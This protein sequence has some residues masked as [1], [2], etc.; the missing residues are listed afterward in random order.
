MTTTFRIKRRA[1]VVH[2][3]VLLTCFIT[4]CASN[5]FAP[6]AYGA[7]KNAEP[8]AGVLAGYY[9]V[10]A[11]DT[12]STVAQAFGRDTASLARWNGITDRDSLTPGR[13]LR[14]APPADEV[15]AAKAVQPVAVKPA[16]VAPSPSTSSAATPT[17]TP[18]ASSCRANGMSWPVK[19]AVLTPFGKTSPTGMVI[20]G[21]KGDTVY[22]ADAGRVVYAGNGVKGYSQLVIVKHD[23]KLLSA[24]GYNQ[25]A[26]VKDGE[27]VKRGQAI[28]EMGH[29]PSGKAAVL[30][31]VR[32]DRKAVD[33][34]PYLKRCD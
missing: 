21:K 25:R 12:L 28:A 8:P 11:G 19:G 16:N 32:K 31:E 26:L 3:L 14:V 20:G 7:S 9:R 22:A 30:F 23:D 2:S 13:V 10:N 4:G 17:A 6:N 24:Y 1:S 34:M 29:A 5:P 18:T 33:P 27:K 15:S